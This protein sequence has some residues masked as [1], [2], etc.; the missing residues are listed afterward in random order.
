LDKALS[1]APNDPEIIAYASRS[2]ARVGRIREAVALAK[3]S[4]DLDPRNLQAANTYAVVLASAGRSAESRELSD[5]FLALWPDA[6]VLYFNAIS[7]AGLTQDWDRVEA[8]ARL[9]REHGLGQHERIRNVLRYAR[10]LKTRDP[11]YAAR[12]L[13]YARGELD[14]TGAVRE[15]DVSLLCALGLADDA[16]D[17]VE[18]SSF[19]YVTDASKPQAEASTAQAIVSAA[20]S[21]ELIRD[22]RYPRLCARLGLCDYWVQTDRWPDFVE[23]GVTP[24]PFK[25][26][27]RLMVARP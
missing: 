7:D 26:A 3:Q 6:L 19:D 5:R 12:F 22:P 24:Y 9:A 27:C 18:R 20:R 13:H 14:R 1:H 2:R 25:D 21:I 4:L 11:D 8:L 16:F 10:N 15:I 17:L 23:D